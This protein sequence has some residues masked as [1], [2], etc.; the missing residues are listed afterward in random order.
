MSSGP[1]STS[2]NEA[3]AL[4]RPSELI[5]LLD[6]DNSDRV[7]Q[8]KSLIQENLYTSKDPSLLNALVDC[9]LDTRSTT[10]LQILTNVHEARINVSQVK[11][12]LQ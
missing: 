2:S 9:F 3:T 7:E 12:S 5:A 11:C 6:S 4:D 1:S 10:A 8:T